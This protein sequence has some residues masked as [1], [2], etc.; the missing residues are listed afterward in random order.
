M[1]MFLTWIILYLQLRRYFKGRLASLSA[2]VLC[3]V[4]IQILIYTS[5]WLQCPRLTYTGVPV[6]ASTLAYWSCHIFLCWWKHPCLNSRSMDFPPCVVTPRAY[7][8]CMHI[9]SLIVGY[10]SECVCYL[11]TVHNGYI[12]PTD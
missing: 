3:I 4:Y 10:A 5:T 11:V 7:H 6:A 9:M 8:M 2:I 1:Y 12:H